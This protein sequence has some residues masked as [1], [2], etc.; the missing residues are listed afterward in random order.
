MVTEINLVLD[1]KTKDVR[2]ELSTSTNHIVDQATLTPDKKITKIIAKW[3]PLFHASGNTPVGT[4]TADIKRGGT[5]GSDRGVESPAGNLVADAQLWATSSNF[6]QVA[7]MNPGGVRSDLT[8]FQSG[9][10]GDG[11]VTFGQ[12]FTFQ[13]FGNTLVTYAM[14]GAQIKAMLAQQCQPAGSSRAFLHLACRKDSPTTW[15]RPSWPVTAPR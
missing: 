15:P 9:T 14:T 12:A 7:F 11:V 2:R 5:S 13:P 6:A 1:K 4:I 8:Y 10:E 3:Q